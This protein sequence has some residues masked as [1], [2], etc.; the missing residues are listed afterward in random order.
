MSEIGK[1]IADIEGGK[2]E[3]Q[4][5]DLIELVQWEYK[6]A[7]IALFPPSK[8][9][10]P[11]GTIQSKMLQEELNKYGADGWELVSISQGLMNLDYVDGYAV[12]RRRIV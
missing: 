3:L 7:Y 6:H 9:K 2:T 11:D 10:D 5:H 1:R 12:F 4:E 8:D